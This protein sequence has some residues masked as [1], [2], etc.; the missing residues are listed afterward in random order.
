M[1]DF[2]PRHVD[3]FSGGSLTPDSADHND[4]VVSWEELFRF[5]DGRHWVL[6]ERATISDYI[7]QQL[8]K[9]Q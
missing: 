3:Y 5:A 1:E 2:F 8:L 4:I 6:R 7:E 9:V